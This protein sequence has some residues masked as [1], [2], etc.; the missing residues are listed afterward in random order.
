MPY[1]KVYLEH[2]ILKV[3][4]LVYKQD[5][6]V[7]GMTTLMVFQIKKKNVLLNFSRISQISESL[8]DFVWKRNKVCA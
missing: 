3:D 1:C 6:R 4:G 7:Y 2:F 8:L 5:A